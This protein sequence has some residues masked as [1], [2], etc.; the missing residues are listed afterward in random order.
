MADGGGDGRRKHSAS[1]ASGK[2]PVKESSR[3]KAHISS[4]SG[5]ATASVPRKLSKSHSRSKLSS[6]TPKSP[7][8]DVPTTNDNDHVAEPIF[9]SVGSVHGSTRNNYFRTGRQRSGAGA[10]DG[11]DAK[12]KSNPVGLSR[13]DTSG[14]LGRNTTRGETAHLPKDDRPGA[15]APSA[16]SPGPG[17][18]PASGNTSADEQV[19]KEVRRG[20]YIGKVKAKLV[21]PMKRNKESGNPRSAGGKVSTP[22]SLLSASS[23]PSSPRKEHPQPNADSSSSYEDDAAD[24]EPTSA[25]QYPFPMKDDKKKRLPP[26]I[27]TGHSQSQ[28]SALSATPTNTTTSPKALLSP[29][30]ILRPKTVPP[31]VASADAVSQVHSTTG[32]KASILKRGNKNPETS[33]PDTRALESLKEPT[34]RP[35]GPKGTSTASFLGSTRSKKPSMNS[36]R[37]VS[38]SP[39]EDGVGEE[40]VSRAPTSTP[41]IPIS[42]PTVRDTQ[43]PVRSLSTTATLSQSLREGSSDDKNHQATNAVLSHQ[44]RTDPLPS[45]NRQYAL[46]SGNQSGEAVANDRSSEAPNVATALGPQSSTPT[47]TDRPHA[48][49]S[50]SAIKI[51]SIVSAPKSVPPST[52][53]EGTPT[54]GRKSPTFEPPMPDAESAPKVEPAPPSGMYWSRAPCFGHDHGALRAHTTTLV[55]SNIYVFGGCDSSAC[56]NDLYILDADCMFW[57]H[58]TCSGTLPPALRAMTATAVGKKI[59][60]FGGGDGP[61]YYNDVY[62]LDTLN[63]RFTKPTISGTAPSRRRAHTA[64]LYKAGIYVFGGGD[65][66]KALNDVWRLDVSELANS[67]VSWRLVSAPSK[68]AARPT[69]RGYHTA[70]MVGS[71]LIIFGGSDGLECFRDVWVF[72]VETLVWRVVD[73]KVAYPRLSHSSTVVGSYLFVVGGHDG[74]EYSNDLL[75]L[76]LVTMQ[77]D[78]RKVHGIPPSGRGYHGAVLYDSRVFMIGGFDG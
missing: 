9:G 54:R 41:E 4:S 22:T 14:T 62:V 57:A 11:E 50:T 74:V 8:A 34:Q 37:E 63:C 44:S 76:N 2:S 53:T 40:S 28:K 43:R 18:E 59:V 49:R 30:D 26:P 15:N 69:A 27:S 78:R 58:P 47:V 42:S 10:D 35:L 55:G 60:F 24:E 33:P 31:R 23:L 6:S 45:S 36:I 71:K 68:S 51:N 29:G 20:S 67:K 46:R 7:T 64:C 73:I 12:Q 52:A 17:S 32:P 56:F 77:W 75:L 3:S 70:N 65:G 38:A 66:V 5:N 39:S 25:Q 19:G 21:L 48:P 72:D 1:S 13:I 16:G 61:N